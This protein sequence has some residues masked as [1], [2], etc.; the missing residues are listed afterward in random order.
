MTQVSANSANQT[1]APPTRYEDALSEL[2]RLVLNM[3][4]GS[5]PL[6]QLLAGYQ[7][8]A[9]LLNFCRACLET[10]E[11]QVQVLEDGQ[12]KSLNAL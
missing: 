12:L 10:V 9:Q 7:R 4:Q 2:E 5:L 1:A 6:D 11:Q 3:E 8:G